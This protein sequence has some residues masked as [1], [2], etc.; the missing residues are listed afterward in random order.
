MRLYATTVAAIKA[1]AGE[2]HDELGAGLAS[3]I[4]SNRRK[5]PV[6]GFTK[7]LVGRPLRR[8]AFQQLLH[9]L[10]KAENVLRTFPCL[11]HAISHHQADDELE[12]RHPS[13]QLSLFV[14]RRV[15][16]RYYPS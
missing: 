5:E 1:S 13:E 14:W 16:H 2:G 9:D 7:L 11:E 15:R 3:N 12:N 10:A 4:R 6:S 8:S